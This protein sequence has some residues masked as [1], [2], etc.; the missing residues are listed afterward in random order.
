MKGLVSN[1]NKKEDTA[2]TAAA[3]HSLASISCLL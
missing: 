2:A 1:S 3:P